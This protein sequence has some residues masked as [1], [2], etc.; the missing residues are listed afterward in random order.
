MDHR[1]AFPDREGPPRDFVAR[2]VFSLTFFL[3]SIITISISSILSSRAPSI[4]YSPSRR[5]LNPICQ[6][7]PYHYR[8]I[9]PEPVRRGHHHTIISFTARN[10]NGT[11][12]EES[13]LSGT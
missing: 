7:N 9:N 10:S 13:V 3:L 12:A 6:G 5:H 1:L 11:Q 4:L 2:F 8:L